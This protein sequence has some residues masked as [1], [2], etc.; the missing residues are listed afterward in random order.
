MKTLRNLAVLLLLAAC[1]VSCGSGRPY[2]TVANDPLETRIYTLDNGLKIYMTVQREVPRIQAYIAVRAGSKNDPRET[3]GL[4][5]YFEH[6]MF[7]G[8]QQF[9][10]TDYAAEKPL[11]D[12]I[13]QLFETYRTTADPARRAD[14]YRQI[15]S[16]SYLASEYAVPNEYDKLMSVIGA[17]GSNA[18]TSYDQT[19]FVEEIPANEFER[20]AM[21]QADRFRHPVI[22]GFHTE[23]ETVYEENNMNMTDDSRKVLETALAKLYPDHPYGMQTVLGTQED[24][25]N[26]SITN[27]K[28]FYDTWYVPNNIAICLSGDLDPE[29]TVEIIERYFGDMEPSYDLPAQAQVTDAPITQPIEA[30]ITGNDADI[31]TVAWRLDG[32]ASPE[33]DLAG[34]VN[35]I[36][37]NGQAGLIDADLNQ[38]QRLLAAYAVTM[39]LAERSMLLLQGIPA[40]GQTLEDVRDLLLA[41]V[42][43][44][45]AGDFD[46]E[47][48]EAAVNNAQMDLMREM[49]SNDGRASIYMQTFCYGIPWPEQVNRYMHA[50]DVT[51]EDVVRFANEQLGPDNYLVI[52]KRQGQDPAARKIAKPRITPLATNRDARSTFMD[53]LMRMPVK[54]IEPVFLDYGRDLV[55]L[56]TGSGL[57]VLYKKNETTGL[58]ELT[59]L[60]D[61]GNLN[62]PALRYAF[63]YFNYL[64]TETKTAEQIGRELYEIACSIDFTAGS[65]RSAIVLSGLSDNMNRTIEI[66]TEL[67]TGAKADPVVLESL[68]ADILQQRRDSKLNKDANFAALRRYADYG[69]DQVRAM[70]LSDEQIEAL[71]AQALI[72]RV[73]GLFD[74]SHT[75][76]YY[77]PQASKTLVKNLDKV[78]LT[79]ETKPVPERHA[80]KLKRMKTPENRVL[81]AQYDA[82]QVSYIQTSNLGEP[83]DAADDARITLFNEYFGGSMNSIVFQE[84]REARSLAYSASA[85]YADPHY[86]DEPYTFMAYIGTQNDKLG[87]AIDAFSEI[88]EQ[89][90]RSEEAFN[91]AKEALLNRLRTERIIKGDVLRAY[92]NDRDLGLDHD[93]RQAI[94]EQVQ[95]LT[96]DDVEAFHNDRIRNRTY[97]YSVLGDIRDLDQEK[98]RSLGPVTVLSQQDIFGY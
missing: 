41:E 63:D 94:Y 74:Q 92:L 18:F 4:A 89:M 16:I 43:K 55:R 2:E 44:L 82:P 93:R 84:M 87:Q 65:D 81:L 54:P 1:L 79:P 15:D 86:A 56:T 83:F 13:E 19:V 62:D 72:D 40:T 77:G 39:P 70:T 53:S 28:K 7:K 11:L 47:L 9:G 33:S 80:G 58:F 27:I 76:L 49:D 23:L 37:Y 29:A 96:F 69:P 90:P 10:T 95:Q 67:V 36:L 31:V 88:I 22:R 48:V 61:T 59:F 57:P 38:Q 6:L 5:H 3:T 71:D 42:A 12:R 68:K 78:Q 26:P 98:L 30:E 52:N 20:W 24:L 46:E 66:F 97:T 51:K 14:L 34:I 73:R 50:T 17:A 35:R 25:K 8:T 85:L 91:I 60:F 21:I 75:I 45:R 32:A 64:G